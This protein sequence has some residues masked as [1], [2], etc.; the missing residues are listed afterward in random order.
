MSPFEI[1]LPDQ[2]LGDSIPGDYGAKHTVA[3]Y[4][5]SD[6]SANL[7]NGQWQHGWIGS[8]KNRHP[9]HIIGGNGKAFRN[10][11]RSWFFVAR[12]DQKLALEQFGFRYVSAIGHPIVYEQFP[13]VS[14][15]ASSLLV[16]P[17]HSLP[18]TSENWKEDSKI[19]A[20]YIASI[21]PFFESVVACVHPVCI[22]KGYWAPDFEKVGIRLITGADPSDSNALRRLAM[23]FSQFEYVTTNGHGSHIAYSS[24]FGCK[25]SVAGP[26]PRWSSDQRQDQFFKN[27]PELLGDFL[28]WRQTDY[29][30]RLY[31]QFSCEPIQARFN[32]EWA[33]HELGFDQ[34]L[35][36]VELKQAFDQTKKGRLNRILRNLGLTNK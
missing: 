19:Y 13:S 9:E 33:N 17:M 2:L 15:R 25:V 23:L 32:L 12:K 18:E 1:V 3:R 26:K 34:K 28:M 11:K 24:F 21:A 7:F 29:L 5:S 16:M 31:P 30:D 35:N 6:Y 36:P 14:R 22:E 20:D 4:L 10:R 8:Y 27:S